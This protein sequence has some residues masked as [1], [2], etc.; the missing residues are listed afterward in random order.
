MSLFAECLTLSKDGLCRGPALPSAALG[1]LPLCR[2]PVFRHSAKLR[3]LGKERVSCS[4]CFS[5]CSC[6]SVRHL[7]C[8]DSFSSNQLVILLQN[9]GHI[10]ILVSNAAANPTV[11]GIL[12][13]K[14]AVLD[15][16]WDI[17][18]KASILLLQ[19]SKFFH[20]LYILYQ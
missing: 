8:D 15:K 1:K 7:G 2:V 6:L 3:A 9:F 10:D 18:V 20:L 12:E 4:E 19:V 11:N 17:N 16:L 5:F 14:E 13:M